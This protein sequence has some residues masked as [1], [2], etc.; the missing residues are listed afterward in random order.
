MT[1]ARTR[2]RLSVQ[3]LEDRTTPNSAHGGTAFALTD[4]PAQPPMLRTFDLLYPHLPFNTVTL[5]GVAASDTLVGIDVRPQN[6]M[7]YA[8]GIDATAD[9]ATVYAVTPRT[10]LAAPVGPP[11]AVGVDLPTDGYGFDFNPTVDRLRVVTTTGLNFRLDPNS[12]GLVMVDGAINGQTM[13]VGGTAYSNNVP[14]AA[15]TVQYTLDAGS[16]KIFTQNPPNA[17]TQELGAFVTVG[18]VPLDFSAVEGFDIAVNSTGYA[19]LTVGGRQGL[20][21]LT[22][23]NSQSNGQATLLGEIGLGPTLMPVHGLAVTAPDPATTAIALTADG[24]ALGRFSVN[25]PNF[26]AANVNITGV[27]DGETLVGIDYRPNTGQLFGLGINA[28][29][30]TGTLYRI[31]PQ[32]GSVTVIGL[33]G[34]VAFKTTGGTV[35]DLPDATSGYGFDFNPTVDRIRVTTGSGLNFRLNPTVMAGV[36]PAVDGNAGGDFTNPDGGTNVGGSPVMGITGTAY[37]NSFG[38]EAGGV[39]TQYTLNSDTNT[40]AIQSPPNAGTQTAAVGVTVGGNPLDF[41]A[42]GGFDIPA[43][44]GVTASNATAAGLGYA[45]LTVGATT[46]LYAINLTTG[47]ATSLGLV[48]TG[49]QPLAGLALGNV[50]GPRVLEL[51]ALYGPS[52]SNSVDLLT[53]TRVLPFQVTGLRVRLSQQLDGETAAGLTINA[54][55]ATSVSEAGTTYTFGFAAPASGTV[56][57]VLAGTGPD[58]LRTAAGIPLLAGLNFTRTFAARYGDVNGDN[59]VTTADLTQVSLAIRTGSNDP[60]ADVNG[61]GVVNN[62]DFNIVRSRIGR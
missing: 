19:V 25:S 41:T 6:G 30:D 58:A 44:V 48:G 38:Q 42:V 29:A 32:K 50:A 7:L 34:G 51:E 5:T 60:F 53:T 23:G 26:L 55:A 20:Y 15:N 31:D 52:N 4:L 28:A 62:T 2:T 49:L 10:G 56:T 18:G 3:P 59:K 14:N 16:N 35:I 8:L 1:P 21:R 46:G 27:T 17:G 12:G 61:D 47:A 13:S 40:L 9:T 54:T 36:S 22:V 39:T 24:L 45:V 57:A 43:P 33:A 37:T 11:A